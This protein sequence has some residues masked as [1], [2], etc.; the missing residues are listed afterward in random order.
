MPIP[1]PYSA[2]SPFIQSDIGE[3]LDLFQSAYKN[4]DVP[5]DEYAWFTRDLEGSLDPAQHY[6]LTFF[7]IEHDNKIIA[8]AAIGKS[9]F[10]R[11]SWELRWG[12]T[13]PAFQRQGLMSLLT[14]YRIAYAREHSPNIPGI[15]HICARS[16][17]L[18]LKKGFRHIYT[19][20]PKNKAHYLVKYIHQDW[21]DN[22]A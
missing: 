3:A 16:P 22:P 8:I 21:Q 7:K 9:G 2:V 5:A 18:Y 13:R 14:D 6:R 17:N 10:M 20:G 12:T 19:R 11:G 4:M 15:I 1:T